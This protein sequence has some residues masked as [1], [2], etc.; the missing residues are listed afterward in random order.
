MI[1]RQTFTDTHDLLRLFIIL[2]DVF[3]VEIPSQMI[4]SMIKWLVHVVAHVQKLKCHHH[5][6][7]KQDFSLTDKTDND[8]EHV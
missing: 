2:S 6:E 5:Q 4:V 1:V 3:V 7:R 8:R